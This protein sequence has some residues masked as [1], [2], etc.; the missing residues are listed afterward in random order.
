MKIRATLIAIGM[1]AAATTSSRAADPAVLKFGSFTPPKAG[2]LQQIT[3]PWLRKMEADSAGTLKFQE[4]WGGA[5]IRSPRKQ[6]EGLMNGIQ[7]VSQVLPSYTAKLFP[8]FTFFDLPLLFDDTGAEEASIVGW[9]MFERGLIGGLEK[10]HVMTL[11]ANDN[12]GLH[13]NRKIETLDGIKGLKVRVPGPKQQ[14]WSRNSG[15]FRSVW[16]RRRSP[17]R[18]IAA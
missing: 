4:F 17:S 7:D 3:K 9:K 10:V 1:A 8:D 16:E 14:P 2:Y 15:W 12:G 18:S 6:W 11:Y 13:F 5:L